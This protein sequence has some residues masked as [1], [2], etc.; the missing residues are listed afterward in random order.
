MVV[1]LDPSYKSGSHWVAL[2]ISPSDFAADEY[3]DSY[4]LP[5][6]NT[7]LNY[8]EGKYIFSK[9]QLQSFTSTICGQWCIFYIWKRCQGLGLDEIVAQFKGSQPEKNDAYVNNVVNKHFTGKKQKVCDVDFFYR[10][11]ALSFEQR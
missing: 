2:C 7:I 4:G 11:T 6:C 3:F 5:P 1:N 10:Q 9:K 8:L